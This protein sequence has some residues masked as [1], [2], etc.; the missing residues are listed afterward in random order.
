MS[1]HTH[2]WLD[3]QRAADH[4]WLERQRADDR[5]WLATQMEDS[6]NQHALTNKVRRRNCAVL[7]LCAFVL[8]GTCGAIGVLLGW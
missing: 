5:A 3:S 7:V 4:Q 8:G 6:R 1:E 2:Q